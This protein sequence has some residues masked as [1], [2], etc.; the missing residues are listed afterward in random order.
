MIRSKFSDLNDIVEIHTR[1]HFLIL[2]K[3]WAALLRVAY[4]L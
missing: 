4:L 2:L 3:I 1:S